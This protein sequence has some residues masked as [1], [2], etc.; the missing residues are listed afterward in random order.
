MRHVLILQNIFVLGAFLS[1]ATIGKTSFN[2]ETCCNANCR[3]IHQ[4]ANVQYGK[5][6]NASKSQRISRPCEY[7]LS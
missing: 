4:V 5:Q 3:R 7:T 1:L 6:Y 2:V